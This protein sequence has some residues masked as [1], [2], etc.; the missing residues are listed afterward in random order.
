V[1]HFS[2]RKTGRG[3]SEP[4]SRVRSTFEYGLLEQE[5][6]LPN[7]QVERA[8]KTVKKIADPKLTLYPS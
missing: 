2:K 1:K 8:K 6:E 3:S 4:N 7:S 5:I